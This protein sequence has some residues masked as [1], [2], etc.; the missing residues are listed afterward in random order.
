MDGGVVVEV[1]L[2]GRRNSWVMAARIDES[3]RRIR[4]KREEN[5]PIPIEANPK[6]VLNHARNVRSF[7]R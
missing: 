1:V 7:A 5:T 2:E 6:V 3:V 4:G